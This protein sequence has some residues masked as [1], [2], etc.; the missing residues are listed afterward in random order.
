MENQGLRKYITVDDI[1]EIWEKLQ[2]APMMQ[3]LTY[4]LDNWY[5]LTDEIKRIQLKCEE[6]VVKQVLEQYLSRPI[7]LEDAKD[8]KRI[9]Y[10]DEFTKYILAYKDTQLGMIKNI[11]ETSKVTVEFHPN[12][13]KF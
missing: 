12:E 6:D 8:V 9:Y 10:K 11:Y 2:S 1:N 3:E 7:T 5:S 13:F 4:D